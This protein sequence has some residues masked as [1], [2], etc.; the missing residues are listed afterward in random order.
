[1]LYTQGQIVAGREFEIASETRITVQKSRTETDEIHWD[2]EEK[3]VLYIIVNDVIQ[4]YNK[5]H[6][7][8]SLKLNALRT[9][10]RD[11]P[12]Y[13]GQI[14]SHRFPYEQ[15]A[16]EPDPLKR[17]IKKAERNTSCIA[18]DYAKLATAG[19]DLDKMKVFQD[20]VAPN[21]PLSAKLQPT[22]TSSSSNIEVI[23]DE[24]PF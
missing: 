7:S 22:D 19:I 13:L 17:V 21:L 24:L 12:S 5:L 15:E 6:S 3:K 18:L 20:K 4:I 23:D 16:W 14:K 9:Y 11:H 1:M 2:G 10:L 8:E